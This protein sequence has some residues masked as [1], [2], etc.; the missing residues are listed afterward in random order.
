MWKSLAAA[1]LSLGVLAFAV[2]P[3]LAAGGCSS[4]TAQSDASL[5]VAQIDQSSVPLPQTP[6]PVETAK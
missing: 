5:E 1:V 3:A 6:R 4:V 2:G